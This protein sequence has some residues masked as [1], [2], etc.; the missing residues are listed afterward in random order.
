MWLEATELLE[1]YPWKHWKNI[2]AKVDRDNV[3]IELVDIWH[4]VMS[5][6]VREYRKNH[7]FDNQ[8]DENMIRELASTLTDKT[9]LSLW[10]NVQYNAKILNEHK[11][12]TIDKEMEWIENFT[13]IVL[14]KRQDGEPIWIANTFF[15]LANAL[16]F[17]FDELYALYLGKDVLN[18]F[19]QDYGYKEGTYEKIW[20]NGKE[21]NVIL[22][23]ILQETLV[24]AQNIKPKELYKKLEERYQK[25][26]DKIT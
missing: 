9:Y 25:H 14:S 17:G 6:L 13:R 1:S 4:F 19:R 5:E 26:I 12:K 22:Q 23:E 24:Q 15:K 10:G 18:K 2:N 3:K 8:N 16:H 21:D 20:D 7:N 11:A